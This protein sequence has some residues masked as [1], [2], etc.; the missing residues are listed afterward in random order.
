MHFKV[1]CPLGQC[2]MIY[3]VMKVDIKVISIQSVISRSGNRLVGGVCQ[4]F[5]L[6]PPNGL[7]IM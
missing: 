3:Y 5:N 1:F 7:K 6:P 4:D 2:S